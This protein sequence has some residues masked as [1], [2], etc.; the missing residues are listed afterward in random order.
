MQQIHASSFWIA[1]LG[2]AFALKLYTDTPTEVCFLLHFG[3]NRILLDRHCR[4]KLLI[5]SVSTLSF[6]ISTFSAVLALDFTAPVVLSSMATHP[7]AA[8]ALCEKVSSRT[9][10]AYSAS[11]DCSML[12]CAVIEQAKASKHGGS[13][14]GVTGVGS[15]VAGAT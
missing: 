13:C 10:G 15:G 2:E 3:V 11:E 5:L 12:E 9:F 8:S 7:C 4:R 14:E 6:F 1:L